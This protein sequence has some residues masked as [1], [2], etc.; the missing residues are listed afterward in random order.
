MKWNKTN[1][2][3]FYAKIILLRGAPYAEIILICSLRNENKL[4][5][6]VCYSSY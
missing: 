3:E 4:T 1:R 6:N 2:S 5:I